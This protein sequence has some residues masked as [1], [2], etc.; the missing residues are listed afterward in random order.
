VS[1]FNRVSW[2]PQYSKIL[3][4]LK[5]QGKNTTKMHAEN[6]SVQK[7][8]LEQTLKIH[9][10]VTK[11][12]RRPDPGRLIRHRRRL[13]RLHPLREAVNLSAVSLRDGGLTPVA[14]PMRSAFDPARDCD[15]RRGIIVY[16]IRGG[17]R[18]LDPVAQ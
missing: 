15:R 3:E 10:S 14:S 8:M 1:Q 2:D 11:L 18:V 9:G 7:A 5:Q 17:V 6:K 4:R 13:G 16:P 12:G